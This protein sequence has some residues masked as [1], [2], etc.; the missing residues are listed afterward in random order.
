MTRKALAL[1]NGFSMEMLPEQALG[2]GKRVGLDY[3]FNHKYRKNGKGK[4][5]RFHYTQEGHHWSCF[6]LRPYLFAAKT[7]SRPGAKGRTAANLRGLD[8]HIIVDPDTPKETE[9][10][11]S[12]GPAHIQAITDWV[13]AGRVLMIISSMELKYLNRLAQHFEM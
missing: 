13:K 10:P 9:T 5:Y 1:D 8:L 7:L 2:Q 6:T 12:V 4:M 11:Y 3:F